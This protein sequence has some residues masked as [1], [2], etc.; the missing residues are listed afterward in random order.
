MKL[1]F[2]FIYLFIAL[3]VISQNVDF[4]KGSVSEKKYY[5]E[6]SFDLV[7]DKIII[8]VTINNKTYR[9]L[10]DTGAPNVISKKLFDE[11]K[12]EKKNKVIVN[13]ANNIDQ[14]LTTTEISSLK[15]GALTFTNQIAIV[16]DLAN[17]NV[18]SCFGIDGFI[19]SN[20]LRNS[21]LKISSKENKIILTNT[22]KNINPQKKPTKIKL[23][24]SQKAPYIEF[25]FIGKN[26]V[27]VTDMVLID[28][29]M[30]GFYEMSNRAYKMFEEHH[31]FDVLGSNIGVTNIGLFGAGNPS[32]Q[33]LM[34]VETG[35]LNNSAIK[36]LILTT[37]ED[38]NSRIG[39]DFLKYGDFILDFNKEN[40]Y[41]EFADNVTLQTK[42]PKYHATVIENKYVIGIVWDKNYAEKM[43]LGDEIIRIEDH[44]INEM[45]F[46][47]ILE[48]KT[49]IKDLKNYEIEIKNKEN[50]NNIIQIE[51]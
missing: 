17:H 16:Y 25:D 5:E 51:N 21:I 33:K 39:L 11:L 49:Q 24:G 29:G 15:I 46:C 18:L 20:L 4:D 19:G 48:L 8:P 31:V 7:F 37:V 44:I 45:T 27:E 35:I 14:S 38:T 30:S 13:D 10:L 50:K 43:S 2:T 12:T 22:I 32:E 40:A 3:K 1:Y 26:K 9:F 47:Q 41:F 6:V 28:T 23:I 36:N 42:I 34:Q